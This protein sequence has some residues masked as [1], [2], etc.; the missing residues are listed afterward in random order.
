MLYNLVQDLLMQV[1][2]YEETAAK[3]ADDLLAF[4]EW[5]RSRYPLPPNPGRGAEQAEGRS[6]D[7][8]I[9]TAIVHLYRYAKNEA[10]QAIADTPFSTIDEFIYLIVLMVHGQMSKTALIKSNIHD[11]PSGTLIINRL[12]AKNWVSQLPALSDKRIM[13]VEL[14]DYGRETLSHH[15]QRIRE[16]S[17]RV[18]APLSE[19]EKSTLAALLIKLENFHQKQNI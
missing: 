11:K 10:K 3:P 14:S 9:N 8:I 7:S 12:I 2:D 4:L 18:T 16:V 6:M 5:Q 19:S 17:A 1:R 13:L 15:M